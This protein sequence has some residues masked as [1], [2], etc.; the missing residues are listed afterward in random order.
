MS[1]RVIPAALFGFR[2][3]H[4]ASPNPQPSPDPTMPGLPES[5]RLTLASAMGYLHARLELLSL[6]AKDAGA[7]Y[8]KLA[9][10]L[11]C[12]VMFLLTGLLFLLMSAVYAVAALFS[13]RWG[14]V[15]LGF[16]VI[17]LVLVAVL[18]LIAKS[19]FKVAS[20]PATI[21]EFKKDK[22]WLSQ[23]K[24]PR[25]QTLSVVRTN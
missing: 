7:N 21:A 5:I 23:T 19:R 17:S 20:F 11:V 22:E 24:P 10:V 16:A 12:A 9:I 3:Y 2:F 1:R 8:V 25:S 18:A 15:F 14:W 6:E 13:F 4:M